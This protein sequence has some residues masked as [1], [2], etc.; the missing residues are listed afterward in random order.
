[1]EIKMKKFG[2]IALFA[3]ALAGCQTDNPNDRALGGGAIGAA[4]GALI[5]A[6]VT[7]DAGGALIGAAIGGVSGAAI[8]AATT[9]QR[10][11]TCR[12][13]DRYGNRIRVR[14]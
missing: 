10:V 7:G 13:Y 12:G 5:G 3:L 1:L 8:G 2:A 11:R 14:C 6:A 9:P 4:S